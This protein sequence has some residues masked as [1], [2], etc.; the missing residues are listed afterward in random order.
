MRC[1]FSLSALTLVFLCG[2]IFALD[3]K[4]I[5]NNNREDFPAEF[6]KYHKMFKPQ[7]GESRWMEI[8]WHSSIWEA[9]K[10][11][12]AEGKPLLFWAGSGGAPPAGC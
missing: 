2:T 7:P 11:A 9:R 4:A 12:A 1:K 10:K 8:E 6:E 3:P 5:T